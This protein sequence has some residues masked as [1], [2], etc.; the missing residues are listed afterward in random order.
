[1]AGTLTKAQIKDLNLQYVVRLTVKDAD[2]YIARADKRSARIRKKLKCDLDLP[3]GGTPMQTLD[4]F[5][6]TKKGAPVHVFIHGGYWRNPG[7]TKSTY[8]EMAAPM[9]AAG[10]TVRSGYMGDIGAWGHG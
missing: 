7:I 9:V 5:P 4:V 3:Y 1:M 8:S 6:A 2:D 10:A